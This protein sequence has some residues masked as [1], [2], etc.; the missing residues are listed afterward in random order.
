MK[1][2]QDLSNHFPKKLVLDFFDRVWSAPHELDAIDELMTE[3]YTITTAGKKIT[4]RKEFKKWVGE[5]QKQLLDAKTENI[6]LFYNE[7]KDK[8]VSRWKCSGKNNGLF[9]VEPDNRFVF[10]TGIA[11]WFIKEDRLSE[12]WVERSAYELYQD[13]ISG[14]RENDFV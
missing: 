12:C 10:F 2:E 7:K 5:F 1:N 9:G 8:I 6:E 13:L 3:D 14:K 4:G 11:I